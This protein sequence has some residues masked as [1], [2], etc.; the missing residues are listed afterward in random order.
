MIDAHN[1]LFMFCHKAMSNATS[2]ES[3]VGNIINV[4]HTGKDVMME[5]LPKC[6]DKQSIEGLFSIARKMFTLEKLEE[7]E[8]TIKNRINKVRNLKKPTKLDFLNGNVPLLISGPE[9]KRSIVDQ[10]RVNLSNQVKSEEEILIDKVKNSDKVLI[11]KKAVKIKEIMDELS[12]KQKEISKIKT[13][14][15][16]IQTSEANRL[17][18]ECIEND[19]EKRFQIDYND[20]LKMIVSIEEYR[21]FVKKYEEEKR[22]NRSNLMKIR[23]GTLTRN[24]HLKAA[25]S[26]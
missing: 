1:D 9:K 8:K 13:E 15:E 10:M 18:K 20:L 12:E 2:F 7:G 11:S 6:L 21:K 24:Q 3:L 14:I 5:Y 17:I 25:W 4:W 19:Y 23:F 26:L 22:A 16:E